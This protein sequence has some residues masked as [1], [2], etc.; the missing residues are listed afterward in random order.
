MKLTHGNSVQGNKINVYRVL[1]NS[2]GLSSSWPFG[3]M[4]FKIN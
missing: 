3:K 1:I 4:A 2:A